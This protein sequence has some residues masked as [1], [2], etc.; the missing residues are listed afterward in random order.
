LLC[1]GIRN[2][3][4]PAGEDSNLWVDAVQIEK[5][6]K[7]TP[8]ERDSYKAPPLDPKWLTDAVFDEIPGSL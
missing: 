1:I 4:T 8:Y 7:A 5:G 3:G 2:I 6:T